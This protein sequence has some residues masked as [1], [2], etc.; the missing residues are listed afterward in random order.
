[1]AWSAAVGV[2]WLGPPVYPPSSM[3]PMQ[4]FSVRRHDVSQ[5]RHL[6]IFNG[7]CSRLQPQ[8]VHMY[9]YIW[10]GLRDI[11]ILEPVKNS[12]LEMGGGIGQS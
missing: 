8:T 6:Y 5:S 4:N 3:L 10:E 2:T 9:G 12:P 7:S 1:M 11:R